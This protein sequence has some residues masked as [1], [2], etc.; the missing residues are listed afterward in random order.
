M[1]VEAV[2]EKALLFDGLV[3]V[4]YFQCGMMTSF[5]VVLKGPRA[6]QYAVHTKHPQSFHT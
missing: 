2:V 6:I 5:P 4:E 1:I 3:D